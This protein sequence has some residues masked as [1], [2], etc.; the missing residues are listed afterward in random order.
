MR[1][2]LNDETRKQ[3]LSISYA[4]KEMNNMLL[5]DFYKNMVLKQADSGERYI[6][7]KRPMGCDKEEF[8]KRKGIRGLEQIPYRLLNF[9]LFSHLFISR[10][11]NYINV[12]D[13]NIFAVKD[14]S[15]FESLEIDWDILDELLKEKKIKNIQIFF[16]VLYPYIYQL[17]NNC[18][19]F[20][21]EQKNKD[22]ES[23]FQQKIEELLKNTK[24]M[25]DYENT[26]ESLL[27]FEPL[28]DMAIL[29]EK[30]SPYIYNKDS[31][32]D[33]ELFLNSITPSIGGFKKKFEII[34]NPEDK[35]PLLKIILTQDMEKIE[36]LKEIPRLNKLANYLLEKCSFK[37]S[38]E[39]ANNT[40]L[41]SIL[42]YNEIKDDL[43]N[44][45]NSWNKIRPI[46]ENYGCKQFKNNGIK[47]F[48]E[49]NMNSPISHFLV[50]EGEFG[51]GMVLAA[52]YKKLIE[53][54][55]TFLNQIINSKSEILS[56]FKDQLNQE[57]MIQD[58]TL[59]EIIDLNRI[60]KDILTDI[61]V[62]NS[63]PNI[64]H[65]L[66][67]DKKIDYY[68]IRTFEHDYENIERELGNL[69]LPGLKR[70]K[71][72]EI[73]FIMYRYEGFRGNKSS[74]ITNFNE[75]YPQ[76]ELNKEQVK[77]I[78]NFINRQEVRDK[79]SINNINKKNIKNILFSI[80]LLID[81]IQR[82]NF[83]KM[84]SLYD[85]IKKLPNRI[86]ISDELK[87]FFK[88]NKNYNINNK[89][90]KYFNSLLNDN[91]S[92]RINTLISIFELFEHLCWES[93]KENL[94]GD[95]LQKIDPVW[96][97]KIIKHFNNIEKNQDK[98]IKRIIFCTALRRFISRY[99]TGKRG[100]NE[101]NEN[102]T[103]LNEIVRPELWKPL[104]TELDNFETEIAEIMSVMTDEY[105]GTL[106]VGQAFELY[107]LLGGDNNLLDNAKEN[108]QY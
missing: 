93:L 90:E 73:R 21:T 50:D 51:H 30:F 103:L 106:K 49:I 26:N 32:P 78:F 94:V 102:N 52:I 66:K 57:I 37:Y 4:D 98:I 34:S 95:Y 39:S 38:R 81:Y 80:Q 7:K 15:I 14:T 25:I 23:S 11:L 40:K 87:L 62:K 76:K 35:Y 82:E 99:L 67:T 108:F 83:D 9:L 68:N 28:S 20:E 16:N 85:I 64:F 74:I 86:C 107:N 33:M 56:C 1:I 17:I 12:G 105:D 71:P 104:F 2:F 44:F 31:F 5:D 59:N 6:D 100:E 27:S 29:Y 72:D 3:K 13:L 10:V 22:F 48:T 75:K 8:L 101:I 60:N 18:Q 24:E 55:N 97:G 63:I 58:A 84:D 89:E 42:I 45:I 41:K 61:I 69:L 79:K 46:I 54:Q 43:N 47:Y 92:F 65:S 77:Y 96:A 53:L 70:F 36:L 88:E 91:L 19:F